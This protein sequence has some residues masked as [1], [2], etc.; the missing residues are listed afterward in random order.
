MLIWVYIPSPWY[1]AC[2]CEVFKGC[3]MSVTNIFNEWLLIQ[4]PFA[5]P[6]LYLNQSPYQTSCY[7]WFLPTHTLKYLPTF[8]SHSLARLSTHLLLV[9]LQKPFPFIHLSSSTCS[10]GTTASLQLVQRISRK[11]SR[12]SFTLYHLSPLSAGPTHHQCSVVWFLIL[13][14]KLFNTRRWEVPGLRSISSA[15]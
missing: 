10:Y 9:N 4:P 15:S 8:C 1:S 6:I 7:F 13:H 14:W 12:A 11:H 5:I 2:N 3:W